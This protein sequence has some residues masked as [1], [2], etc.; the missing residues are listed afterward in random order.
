MLDNPKFWV[1]A[2]FIVFVLLA[3]K[4][5]STLL[6][7]MLDDRSA[8]IK[9]E[10]EE[11]QRLRIEAEAVLQEYKQKQAEYLKEAES[12][13]ANANKDA[14][15]LR[16]FSQ[17]ELKATLDA[18]MKQ[19]VDRIAQ[20]ESNAIAEVREHVLDIALAAARALIVD[21]VSNMPQDELVKMALTDIERKIH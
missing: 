7:N 10:L 5:A 17:N 21:H 14:Q 4:K 19:A 20:E 6:I 8:K 11:A 18:R 1:A 16:D 12:I 13:L 9:A 2:A 3:Y 15:A